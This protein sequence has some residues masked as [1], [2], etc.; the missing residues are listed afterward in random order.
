[1]ESQQ[2]RDAEEFEL[3]GLMSEDEN[4]NENGDGSPADSGSGRRKEIGAV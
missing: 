4:E 1:M 2:V 3:E